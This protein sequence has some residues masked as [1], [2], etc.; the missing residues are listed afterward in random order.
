MIYIIIIAVITIILFLVFRK[1]KLQNIETRVFNIKDKRTS[2]FGVE[3]WVEK[4]ASCTANEM[5][6][7][8]E[9]LVNCFA[10]A[11]Q[12]GYT[13]PL[14]HNSYIVAI[15]ADSV[16]SPESR[17]WS[18]KLPA[19]VYANTEWDLGGYIL[20]AGQVIAIGEPYGNIIAIPDHHDTDYT[21]LSQIVMYEAE[22]I[23]L[24]YCD[25]DKYEATKV[26]GQGQGHPLF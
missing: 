20:A 9:G 23:I 13:R 14:E 22:H 3:I 7:I 24:A 15:M 5:S 2:P 26:H 25:G 19:G 21:Q 10:K 16:R 6:F 18:Y 8:E 17:I 11:R 12:A 1:K 4:G